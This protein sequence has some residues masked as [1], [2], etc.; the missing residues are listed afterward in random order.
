LVPRLVTYLVAA[1]AL[2]LCAA[3]GGDDTDDTDA[4]GGA[5][6]VLLTCDE[7]GDCVEAPSGCEKSRE[8]L[9]ANCAPKSGGCE[10][11]AAGAESGG[12]IPAR[13]RWGIVGLDDRFRFCFGLKIVEVSQ[14]PSTAD[15]LP[16]TSGAVETGTTEIDTT[17]TVDSGKTARCTGPSY[18]I[19]GLDLTSIK[20]KLTT[21]SDGQ[22]SWLE[23][24]ISL[25]AKFVNGEFKVTDEH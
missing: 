7:S 6:A 8:C 17:A 25:R 12:L 22:V 2:A 21:S 19:K 4:S 5:T 15:P 14:E 3:C 13:G 9:E 24:E 20:D 18:P 23:E 1:S 16:T 10:L 11:E